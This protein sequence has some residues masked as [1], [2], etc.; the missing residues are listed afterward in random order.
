V[1]LIKKTFKLYQIQEEQIEQMA[2]EV[3]K[4]NNSIV[5]RAALR[6][7]WKQTKRDR[8]LAL[9]KERSL[10]DKDRRDKIEEKRIRRKTA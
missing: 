9:A 6:M 7:L 1:E 4:I 10:A 3:T 2:T 8:V 5:V